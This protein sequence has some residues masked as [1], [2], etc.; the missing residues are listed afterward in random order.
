L[1]CRKLFRREIGEIVRYLPDKNQL[2]FGCLSNCR[3]CADRTQNLPGSAFNMWLTRFQIS[4]KSVYFRRSYSGTR[5]GRSF[6]SWSIFM[7][8]SMSL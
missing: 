6:A 8:S 2:N 1:K 5:A 4:F 3:Y 7:I